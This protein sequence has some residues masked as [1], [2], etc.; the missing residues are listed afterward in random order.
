MLYLCCYVSAV[1]AQLRGVLCLESRHVT[2]VQS[3]SQPGSVISLR[4]HWGRLYSQAHVA[5]GSIPF[6]AEYQSG[7]PQFLAGHQPEVA[8]CSLPHGPLQ[9]VIHRC[10]FKAR[11]SMSI[12]QQDRCFNLT[13]HNHTCNTHT[14]THTL[15]HTHTHIHHPQSRLVERKSQIHLPSREGTSMTV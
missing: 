13:Q 10:F 12:F 9:V 15:T 5:A 3:G 11:K 14:H 6:P 7:G 4:L 1:R 8:L 2:K